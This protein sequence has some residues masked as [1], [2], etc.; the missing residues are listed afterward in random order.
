MV[1]GNHVFK[2][3]VE[4]KSMEESNMAKS[5]T[6]LSYEVGAILNFGKNDKHLVVL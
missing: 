5:K 2:M 3:F 6:K 4:H 1:F